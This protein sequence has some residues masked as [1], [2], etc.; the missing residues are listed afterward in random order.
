MQCSCGQRNWSVTS[1]RKMVG[2]IDRTRICLA[3]GSRYQTEERVRTGKRLK[4]PEADELRSLIDCGEVVPT[5]TTALMTDGSCKRFEP[6]PARE[7][8]CAKPGS[9]AKIEVLRS[10]VERGESLWHELDDRSPTLPP[11]RLEP[12]Q[13]GIREVELL[14]VA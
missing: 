13:P 11:A 9:A 5:I 14:E 8:T 2:R 12:Y 1:T 3:C 7:P 6:K 10:R 4:R